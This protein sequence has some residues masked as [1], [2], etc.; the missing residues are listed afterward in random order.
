[1]LRKRLPVYF[2]R[3]VEAD[4]SRD[5]LFPRESRAEGVNMSVAVISGPETVEDLRIRRSLLE[6]L[7]LKI[8]SLEGE[9]SVCDLGEKMLIP[10]PRI[11]IKF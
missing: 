7:A 11:N 3:G 9:M 4:E 6:D 1:M 5:L 8:L 2:R 10:S